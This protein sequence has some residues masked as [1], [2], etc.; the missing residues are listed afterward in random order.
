MDARGLVRRTIFAV[1]KGS[2]VAE[3]EGTDDY[4]LFETPD[5]VM[6][7]ITSDPGVPQIL[8][9]VTKAQ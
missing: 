7:P 6:E 8:S 9:P 1:I 5:L 3:V 2:L 4:V